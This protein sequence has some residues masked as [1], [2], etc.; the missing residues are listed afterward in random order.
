MKK[1]IFA[2]FMLLALCMT[3]CGGNVK[4]VNRVVGA[5]AFYTEEE[6][7]RAMDIAISYF[8]KNFTGCTMTEIRYDEAIIAREME[9]DAAQYGAE[10]AIVLLS[11][12]ETNEKGGD[13]SSMNPN[14]TYSNWKWI[15]VRSGGGDWEL[16]T[17]GY[18]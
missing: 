8:K 18:G 1:T 4:N 12:Y 15:L 14:R 10:E 13:G 6:I 17:W 2:V 11:D 9:A 16:K 3:G 5:S 7:G